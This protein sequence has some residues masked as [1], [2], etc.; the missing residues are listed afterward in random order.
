MFGQRLSLATTPLRTSVPVL[1]I[2]NVVEKKAPI[3]GAMVARVISGETVMAGDEIVFELQEVTAP[4]TAGSYSFAV[5]FRGQPI[6]ANPMVI[7]QSAEASKLVI[8]APATVVGDA[9][10]APVAVT[11]NVQDAASGAAAVADATTVNLVSTNTTTGSFTAGGAA[12]TDGNH[13][14]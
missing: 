6:A 13:P 7:V 1:H 9:G 14:R 8:D 4:A 10:A 12:V 3:D 5:T 11:I 2:L